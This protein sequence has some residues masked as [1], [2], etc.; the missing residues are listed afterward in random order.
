[1]LFMCKPKLKLN[2]FFGY[3][4]NLCIA[5]KRLN[6]SDTTIPQQKQKTHEAKEQA[7]RVQFERT[8]SQ[9]AMKQSERLGSA[10][11]CKS[12]DRFPR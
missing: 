5:R 6:P 4:Y 8:V 11:S 10:K 1:M 12:K 9:P 2:I 3:E 7:A